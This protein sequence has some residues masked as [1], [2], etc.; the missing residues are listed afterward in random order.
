[1]SEK[2]QITGFSCNIELK[3][4]YFKHGNIHDFV[5]VGFGK[6][7]QDAK[8]MALERLV[9]DLIQTGSIRLGLRDKKFTMEE[10]PTQIKENVYFQQVAK[11]KPRSDFEE[12][13]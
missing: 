7:K 2:L 4:N 10:A 1:M 11:V 8:R 6:R 5:A 9:V 12:K 3:F 13:I